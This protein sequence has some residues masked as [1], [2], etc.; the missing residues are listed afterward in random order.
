MKSF[1]DI[2]VWNKAYELVLKVYK[3]TKEFPSDE[4]FSLTQQIRR[5]AVS[6]IANIAEGNKRKSDKDFG[7][8]LNISEGSLEEVKCYLILSK[9]LNYLNENNYQQLFNLSEEVGRML[10]GFIKSLKT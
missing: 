4:K 9:D 6:I 8:F 7:H 2:K 10:H 5:S 1:R 3:V